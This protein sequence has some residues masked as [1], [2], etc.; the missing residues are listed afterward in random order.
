MAK[1]EDPEF[2]PAMCK[3]PPPYL[4]DNNG[5]WIDHDNPQAGWTLSLFQR[6]GWYVSSIIY[7]R[8]EIQYWGT[9]WYNYDFV[10]I[11]RKLNDD[12]VLEFVIPLTTKE[13]LVGWLNG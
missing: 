9:Y 8:S 6:L 7:P 5:E 4:K 12:G 10:I 1:C 13:S 11:M 3:C 2:H